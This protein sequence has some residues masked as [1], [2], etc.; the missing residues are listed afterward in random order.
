MADTRE[1]DNA[2]PDGQAGGAGERANVPIVMDAPFEPVCALSHGRGA[3]LQQQRGII[4]IFRAENDRD[5]A[6]E[7][8]RQALL[9]AAVDIARRVFESIPPTVDARS[10]RDRHRPVPAE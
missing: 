5:I 2:M 6:A 4:T 3:Y 8:T 10:T 7:V 9:R 1:R